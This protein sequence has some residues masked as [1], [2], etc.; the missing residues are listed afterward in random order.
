MNYDLPKSLNVCGVDY[1][2]RS[3]FR[4]ALDICAA[5]E[6]PELNTQDKVLVALVILYPGF[7]DIPFE[8]YEEA[9]KQCFW[10]I[11]GGSHTPDKKEPKLV[12]W[13]QDA[14][15]IIAP[16][17]RVLGQDIRAVEYNWETNEGGLHWWTFLSAY[18]EI[19]D[20]TFA[21]IVR[22]RN[23]KAKGKKLDKSDQEWYR[24]NR[25]LVDIKTSHTEAEQNVL[26][27]WGCITSD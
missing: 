22:I 6:D 2:I 12:S 9:I 1:E 27:Q 21:Q 24:Q 3:D 10:F 19:G 20:C 5:L 8:H 7:D 26:K 13:N 11:N 4:A 16:I 23:L 14:Q 18:M 15:F 25:E 17:S